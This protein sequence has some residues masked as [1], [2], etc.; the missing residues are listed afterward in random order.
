ML[1]APDGAPVDLSHA[2]LARD[3]DQV[4]SGEKPNGAQKAADPLP[5]GDRRHSD[6][7]CG[8]QL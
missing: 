7:I 2:D 1:H 5:A 6:A 4:R 3:D 8:R